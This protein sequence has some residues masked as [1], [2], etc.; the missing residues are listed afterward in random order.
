MADNVARNVLN[1]LVAAVKSANELGIDHKIESARQALQLFRAS[2]RTLM[3]A[4]EDLEMAGQDHI[5]ESIKNECRDL[6]Q[7]FLYDDEH[8][9]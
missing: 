1:G 5:S 7:L 3:T 8:D 4:V 6:V 2:L 9:K